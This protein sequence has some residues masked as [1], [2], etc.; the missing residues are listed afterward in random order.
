MLDLLAGDPENKTPSNR[1]IVLVQSFS[2]D[3]KLCNKLWATKAPE[4]SFAPICS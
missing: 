2:Q 3:N 4:T 1:V